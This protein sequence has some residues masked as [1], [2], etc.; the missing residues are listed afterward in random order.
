MLLALQRILT[1]SRFPRASGYHLFK[2]AYFGRD[3]LEV[4][5]D[6][7]EIRPDIARAVIL[8]LASLQGT[9]IDP[10]TEEEPGKIHHEYRAL[11]IEGE[12]VDEA[13]SRIFHQLA[14]QWQM[15]DTPEGFAALTEFIYYGT[16]DATPLYVRLVSEYARLVSASILE[17]EY[18]PRR[19]EESEP[20][21]TIRESVRRAM[22]WIVHS[23]EDS[24]LGLLEFRRMTARGHRFQAWKDGTTAY[25]HTNGEFANYN[26]PIASIEVQGLAYD[27][28]IAAPSLLP[29]APEEMQ[30]RWKVLAER[31][32]D[33]TLALFWM[34]D[35]QYFAMAL[36]R[37]PTTNEPRQVRLISSNPAA[38]MDSGI[39]DTVPPERRRQAVSAI[40][41][42]IYSSE[43]LTPAGIRCNCVAQRDV[44]DYMAYQS[45]YTVWHKE[46]Y[47]VA[48]GLRR[49]GFPCLARD[50]ETR[51]LNAINITGGATE[52]LYVMPD[53][54]V[55]YDPF[56]RRPGQPTEAVIGTNVPENDQGWSISAALAI[57]WRRGRRERVEPATAGWQAEVEGR[58]L[59]EN[60][61]A[62]LLRTE[63]EIQRARDESDQFSLNAEEAWRREQAFV[64]ARELPA[65]SA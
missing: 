12:D 60:V 55:D 8:R 3:S 59:G 29:D 15:A 57:K 51:I 39:F 4:A 50:L 64:R 6:L 22:S 16:V 21:P 14:E 65:A 58:K 24:D 56:G 1:P 53:G 48:M 19:H 43:F 62:T 20:R 42:R 40:V 63:G 41:G 26:G 9:V 47:D 36:D 32:R 54:R 34:P 17:E 5:E 44:L 46:T 37:D 2:D 30:A 7:L 11:T 52:F 61:P 18:T 25:V 31:V 13:G 23:M 45:S 35:E 49:Q 10:R 33:Q 38:M 28:L 27:A